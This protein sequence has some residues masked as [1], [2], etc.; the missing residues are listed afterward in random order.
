[1]RQHHSLGDITKMY[2]QQLTLQRRPIHWSYTA[3]WYKR[4]RLTHVVPCCKSQ[5][6]KNCIVTNARNVTRDFIEKFNLEQSVAVSH[7]LKTRQNISVQKTRMRLTCLLPIVAQKITTVLGELFAVR[8]WI[9]SSHISQ[10]KDNPTKQRVDCVKHALR[11]L[12]GNRHNGCVQ[13]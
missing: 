8:L 11:Y 7:S 9:R 12:F 13:A 1:M 3:V 2:N 6:C 5:A 4:L 10:F